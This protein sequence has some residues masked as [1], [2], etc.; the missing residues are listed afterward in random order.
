MLTAQ[1]EWGKRL[2]K[3][4]AEERMKSGGYECKGSVKNPRV[5]LP[6]GSSHDL[7][8][9]DEGEELNM[10]ASSICEDLKDQTAKLNLLRLEQISRAI[11]LTDLH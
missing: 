10:T 4:L 9:L 3:Q 2:A 6:L 5:N 8:T 11:G 7:N 1:V